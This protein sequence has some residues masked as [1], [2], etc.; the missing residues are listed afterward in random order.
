M[1]GKTEERFP[2]ARPAF[3][4]ALAPLG[5]GLADGDSGFD[6]SVFPAQRVRAA[7]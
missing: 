3:Q 5:S 1:S 4:E 2:K 6:C 7:G